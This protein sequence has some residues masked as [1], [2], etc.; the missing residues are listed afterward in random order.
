MVSI[1]FVDRYARWVATRTGT[2]RLLDGE[3]GPM[4]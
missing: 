3:A 2:V 1:L 4:R